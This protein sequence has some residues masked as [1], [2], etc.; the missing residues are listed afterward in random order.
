MRAERPLLRIGEYLVG[1]ACQQLPRRIRE[2][3]YQEWVAEL[4]VILHDPQVGPAPRRVVRMLGYAADT[5]RGAALTHARAHARWTA[6]FCLLLATALAVMIWNIV[7]IVGAPGDLLNYVRLAWSVLLAAF[8]LS[9]LMRSAW[10][11]SRLIISG[12]TLVGVAVNSWDAAQAPADWVNYVGAALLFLLLLAMLI[13]GWVRS[14]K[15]R[16]RQAR[17]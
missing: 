8:P 15:T 2:Q 6:V 14:Q 12:S 1:R 9:M 4:P 10:R 11:V 5:L 17:R 16:T 7:A 13:V 3:R